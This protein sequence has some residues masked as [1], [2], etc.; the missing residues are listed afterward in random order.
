MAILIG[1]ASRH[2]I[3]TIV[4]TL[5]ALFANAV[6]AERIKDIASV[7][8]VR[9]NPLLGYGLIVGLDG[10]GDQT[11]QVAFTEQ[12]LRSMLLQFG[13]TVPSN[14]TISPKN[15]AA[16]SIHAVLPPFVKPG[17]TLDV[18]VSSLGNA[19]SLRGGTLLMTPLKGVD[20]QVY[21]VAQGNLIVG[22]LGAEGADGSSVTVNIPSAG[23]IPGG[24][25]V[26]RMVNNQFNED[27]S[28]VLNLHNAD[29]TTAKRV[30][31][32]INEKL[33]T[34]NAQALDPVSIA[35]M[36]PEDLGQ[37]VEF[38]SFL[39]TIE[40]DPAESGAKIII[41][42][43]TGT[44]VIGNHVTVMP[45]AVSHGSLTVTITEDVNVSQPNPLTNGETEITPSSDINIDSESNSLYTFKR[46]VTLQEVV[47]A[48]NQVGASTGDLISIL[49][50]LK[51][52]GALT[53][54]II[55][56]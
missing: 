17:Q 52:A 34:Q 7:A 49:E 51:Q 37:R 40:V 8:G 1:A 4:L 9:E 11:G 50:A 23:R 26:E 5:S 46:G 48:M 33:G 15:V 3:V 2:A 44:I 16:V 10:S 39:E 32:A 14:V 43:R 54:K 42:S 6:Y 45:A 30:E 38:I 31:Q 27:S 19:K 41:N 22:G 28:I 18:T 21:A 36:A 20:G 53:A 35:V 29:F 24:A 55:V 56:I 47:Y 12:S 13:V 25:I